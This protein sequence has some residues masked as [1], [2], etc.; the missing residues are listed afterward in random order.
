MEYLVSIIT[1]LLVLSSMYILV[2]LGFAFL[3]NMMGILNLAHGAIYMVG[4]YF[5]FFLAQAMG[6]NQWLALMVTTLVLAGFGVLLERYCF[7]RFAGD[8]NRTI[9]ACVA[10][11]VILQTAINIMAGTKTQALPPFVEG[12]FRCGP[13]AVSYERI[14]TFFSGAALLVAIIW[15]V[16]KTRYGQQMQAIAQNAEGAT[17]RGI[18]VNKVA[19]IASALACGLAGIAGCLMGALLT[20]SPNMGDYMLVKAL[21]LVILA[22]VGSTGGIF[23]AGLILGALDSILP[24]Y[25]SGAASDAVSVGIVIVLLLIR[26]QGFFGHEY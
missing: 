15:F 22:G 7:R 1:N 11:A 17:L 25:M 9:T 26:P 14:V 4:G 6:L 13:L 2:A 19:S 12:M 18:S 21:V 10:I 16:N 8:F 23:I 20:L 24:V 5:C 3:L